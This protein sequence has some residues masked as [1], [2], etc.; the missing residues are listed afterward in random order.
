MRKES[1]MRAATTTLAAL[2]IAAL[3]LVPSAAV[4]AQSEAPG[5]ST[6]VTGTA[7]EQFGFEGDAVSISIEGDVT[8]EAGHVYM[9][10]MAWSDDRLPAE[11]WIRMDLGF[12]DEGSEDGVMTVQTSHLL[13]DSKGAWRGTGR[14]F[15][16]EDDRYSYYELQGEGAYEGLHALLRGAP[17]VDAHG[18][19]DLEYEGWILQGAL[20]AFPPPV[21]PISAEGF[22]MRA[23]PD[24]DA[25]AGSATSRPSDPMAPAAFYYTLEPEGEPS[26]GTEQ[27]SADGTLIETRDMEVVERIQAADPR[28][29]GLLTSSQ[30]RTQVEVDGNGVQTMSMQLRLSNEGGAWSGPGQAMLGFSDEIIQIA[31]LMTLEG[32]GGYEGLTLFLSQGGDFLSQRYW[33][34]IV[35]TELVA[36][37]PGPVNPSA[38]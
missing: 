13:A 1:A 26:W 14:A 25:T 5:A 34:L 33:G 17:G 4:L 15:E 30:N 3:L 19:W 23:A 11:H 38:D 27:Q 9:Q 35:P 21:E 8:H 29:S 32:E 22:T 6:Y 28:A 31:G 16:T 12:Y 24:L 7:V 20:T 10:R 18:P 36:P 2:A 37:V